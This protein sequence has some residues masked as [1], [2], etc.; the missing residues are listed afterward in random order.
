MFPSISSGLFFMGPDS[1]VVHSPSTFRMRVQATCFFRRPVENPLA[2]RL[3]WSRMG[4]GAL[5][6]ITQKLEPLGLPDS[7]DP[8]GLEDLIFRNEAHFPPLCLRD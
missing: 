5:T 3:S 7:R 1:G 6:S 2:D 4:S 8:V